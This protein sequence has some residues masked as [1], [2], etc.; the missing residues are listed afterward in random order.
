M[1]LEAKRPQS[2][3]WLLVFVLTF[4]GWHWLRLLTALAQWEFLAGL[5]M[6]VPPLYF[7]LSGLLWGLIGIPIAWGLLLGK[8]WTPRALRIAGPAYAFYFWFDRL[9][10]QSN[11]LANTNWRFALAMTILFLVWLNWTLTRPGALAYLGE[12]DG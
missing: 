6:S 9:L 3:T 7:A 5:Q 8:K 1:P 12:R 10:L 4:T 2:V 11:E